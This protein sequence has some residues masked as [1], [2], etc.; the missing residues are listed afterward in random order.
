MSVKR[1]HCNKTENVII[2]WFLQRCIEYIQCGPVARMVSVCPS[3]AWI[4]TKRKK[5]LSRFLYRTKDH[6]AYSFLTEEWLV[7][8]T[9][10]TWNFGSTGPGGA[11][12]PIFNRYSLVAPQP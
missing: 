2:D 11:K 12:S 5:N 4:V 3:N 9:P 6:L 8:A 7:G 1:I 10:S